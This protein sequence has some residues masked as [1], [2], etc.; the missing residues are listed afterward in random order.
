M[1]TIFLTI[2]IFSV[3]FCLGAGTL[4]WATDV[5]ARQQRRLKKRLSGLR[6]LGVSTSR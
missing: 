6:D 5:Q 1:L 3:I 2:C 4:L